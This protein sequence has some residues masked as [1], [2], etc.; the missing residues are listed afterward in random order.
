MSPAPWETELLDILAEMPFLDRLELAAVTGWSRGAAYR[1]VGKL[2]QWGCA[3][4]V[5]HATGLVA[6]T[7]RYRLTSE[8]LRRLA[9]LSDGKVDS[10]LR[11]H[12]V[13]DRWQRIL[14]ER[15]DGVAAIYRL[16][17]T[18]A[19]LAH[20]LRLRWYRAAPLD[21]GIILPAGRT[22]GILRQGRTADRAGFAKRVWRL[23]QGP[24]PGLVLLLVPDEVR[25]R[26]APR[27][28]ARI[29]V[30]ALLALEADAASAGPGQRIWR[31]PAGNAALD[32][33]YAL[34][35]L[36]PGGELPQEEPL[37]NPSL[38][39]ED[40]EAERA[41]PV[42]L[43]A[44]E[45]RALDLLADWPWLS[46]GELAALLDVSEPRVSQLAVSLESHG[47][48]VR[49]KGAGGR[50]ALTDTGLATLAR[51]DRASVSAARK[52]FSVNP[53]DA[54]KPMDWR[55]VSGGRS[56]QLLR[57]L[58]HTAA[59]HG[60][61][62]ALA[63]QARDLDWEVAQLDPPHR[64][65]RHFP[66][67]G[68]QR[69]VHPDASGLLHRG[70]VSWAFILEWERRAVRPATMAQ[71][72]APYL[73]YYSTPRPTDD[74]GVRPAVLVVFDDDLAAG[75][76]LRLAENEMKR[77]GVQV[78][79]WVSHQ[80]AVQSLGPLGRAWRTPGQGEPA[81]LLPA[82][83]ETQFPTRR[84]RGGE[85]LAGLRSL[86]G[87]RA[88]AMPSQHTNRPGGPRGRGGRA[89]VRLDAAD[90]WERLALLGRSQNWLAR[91][92]GVSHAYL[93]ML[94]NG[95][96][97][98]SERIRRRMLKALGLSQFHQLF[99]LEVTDDQP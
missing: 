21:A 16:A 98:P 87:R 77:A 95:G 90:L 27:L 85:K 88:K 11:S 24:L 99:R 29:P 9:E 79:L 57:N 23:G 51:R 75:H 3:A 84:N 53:I 35:R 4:S 91:E 13:S 49:P 52:R 71:R 82:P 81:Q 17:A 40:Q 19:N 34:E 43:K 54:A 36:R 48:A 8:G 83:G 41:L 44:A 1:G 76:F 39:G 30:N 67:Q 60:F 14:L 7:R 70:S 68:G 50:M 31:T 20:P 89:V 42:L 93:S 26:H 92:I 46:R 69:S 62:A 94:V 58:E 18:V 63:S 96:R 66:H 28:L 33:R 86:P 55:N 10:L 2:E 72:L 56:R 61:I 37:P 5:P 32:L 78:P 47:L 22:L 74:H 73:R 65:S 97:A 59:V 64:A 45:K 80:A 38:P 15:L 25:I 6:S 12:P